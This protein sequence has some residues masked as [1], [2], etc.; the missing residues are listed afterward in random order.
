MGG[1]RKVRVLGSA[2]VDRV[3]RLRE[4]GRM[5]EVGSLGEVWRLG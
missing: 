2:E 4:V 5:G 3:R 1:V